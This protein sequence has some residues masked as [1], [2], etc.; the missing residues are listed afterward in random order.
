M[1]AGSHREW[2]VLLVL[3]V[4]ALIFILSYL[5]MDRAEESAEDR[6]SDY[7]QT[8]RDLHYEFQK[9]RDE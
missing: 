9:R 2:P 8:Q 1:N 7:D 3:F 5:F 6:Q 4:T